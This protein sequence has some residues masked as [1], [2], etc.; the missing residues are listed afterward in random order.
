MK[1]PIMVSGETVCT[2]S[3]D[4]F[5]SREPLTGLTQ[6]RVSSGAR[7]ST[8]REGDRTTM[9]FL[10]VVERELPDLWCMPE[11]SASAP[12]ASGWWREGP[13]RQPTVRGTSAAAWGG[14]RAEDARHGPRTGLGEAQEA[15]G[16]H[17][18][19]RQSLGALGRVTRADTPAAT[20]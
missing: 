1:I 11:C 16:F 15:P 14:Q 13:S 18:R 10:R 2:W 7:V 19:K 6:V 4:A 8:H 9:P 3:T 20:P 5:K 12:R 17:S